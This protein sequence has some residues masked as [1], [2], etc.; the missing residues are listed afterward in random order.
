[1]CCQLHAVWLA[2]KVHMNEVFTPHTSRLFNIS[3]KKKKRD[4]DSCTEF[5]G[6]DL[7]SIDINL[8]LFRTPML[9]VD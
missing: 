3:T 2:A 4:N 8:L 9:M 7:F 6:K 1:M 5:Y